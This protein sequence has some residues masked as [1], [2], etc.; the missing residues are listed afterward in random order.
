[1]TLSREVEN[2]SKAGK[3]GERKELS[4]HRAALRAFYRSLELPA[5]VEADNV[6]ALYN[7]VC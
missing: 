6:K 1:L 7:M 2:F 5:D 4:L 3:G